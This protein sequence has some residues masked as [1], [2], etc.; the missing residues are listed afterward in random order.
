VVSVISTGFIRAAA[1]IEKTLRQVKT[2]QDR[3]NITYTQKLNLCLTFLS[4]LEKEGRFFTEQWAESEIPT[5]G[6][7]PLTTSPGCYAVA[8][9][10]LEVNLLMSK[11]VSTLK[12]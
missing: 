10:A 9:I 2:Q 7:E 4:E 6:D 8:I 3:R 11:L 5:A 1:G 12:W